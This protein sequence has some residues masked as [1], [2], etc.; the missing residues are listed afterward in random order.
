MKRE[1]VY[2]GFVKV[3]LVETPVG[4]R[5]VVVVTDSVAIFVYDKTRH[6]VWLVTQDRAPMIR[7][8][9]EAGTITEV[10][11]GRF[12]QAI[13]VRELVQKELDEELGVTG[14]ADR[15]IQILN[16]G[17][18]LALSP[19]VL[20]ERQYLAYVEITQEQIDPANRLYG[21]SDENEQIVRRFIPV[22]QLSQLVCEDMKTWALVQ[23]FLRKMGR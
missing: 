12:D 20:T 9:N 10:P 5:E 22:D 3:G 15:D 7:D 6:L 1:C 17:Q 4:K 19:G 16:D 11:A 8:G 21:A 2:D 14:V 23:W 18:P 13:G